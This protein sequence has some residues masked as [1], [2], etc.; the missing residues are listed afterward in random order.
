M[1]WNGIAPFNAP[2]ETAA[3]YIFPES[4]V[5]EKITVTG[6]CRFCGEP[7]T[8]VIAKANIKRVKMCGT[9][10]CKAMQA[11]ARWRQEAA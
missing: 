5:M 7:Y 4:N 1:N 8:R 2:C 11:N 6:V 9:K 10:K 3:G